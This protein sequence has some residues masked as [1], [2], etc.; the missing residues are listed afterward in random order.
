MASFQDK[1]QQQI[2]AI[3]KEVRP[4]LFGEIARNKLLRSLEL[5][6]DELDYCRALY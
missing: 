6:E 3:D 1:A 4:F 5:L 2:A